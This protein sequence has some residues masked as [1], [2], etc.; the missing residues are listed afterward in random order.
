MVTTV[1]FAE[2]GGVWVGT[3]KVTPSVAMKWKV[4]IEIV[5]LMRIKLKFVSEVKG[6]MRDDIDSNLLLIKTC[7]VYIYRD[8]VGLYFIFVH[9]F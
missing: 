9:Q 2:G 3:V 4:V 5:I 8:A 6:R 7:I 1:G